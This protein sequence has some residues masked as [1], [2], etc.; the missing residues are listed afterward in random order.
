MSE[1]S[2]QK[3]SSEVVAHPAEFVELAGTAYAADAASLD[4]VL[5]VSVRVTAE[6]GRTEMEI[7]DVLHLGLG[8]V[9]KLDRSIFDPVDLLVQGKPFARGEV[10]VVEDRFAVRIKEIISPKKKK[11]SANGEQTESQSP[12]ASSSP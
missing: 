12:A 4:K 1:G 7:G 10:V 8:S 11:E 2:S 6:L 9:V 5:D 3:P